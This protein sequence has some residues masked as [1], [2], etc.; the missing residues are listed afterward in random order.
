V[1]VH[2]STGETLVYPVTT[3][4]N[5]IGVVP[6]IAFSGQLPGRPVTV[7]VSMSYQGLTATTSTSFLIWQ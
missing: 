1:T 2:L 3:D 7:D 6:S 5:G 4:A